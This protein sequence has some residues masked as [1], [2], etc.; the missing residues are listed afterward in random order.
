MNTTG[1][2]QPTPPAC[3]S[4][5]ATQNAWWVRLSKTPENVLMLDYDGTLAPFRVDRM[6]ASPYPG[7]VER[8]ER[9][10]QLGNSKIV[11]VSGRPVSELRKLFPFADKVDLWASHGRE[12][13]TP[14]GDYTLYELT[15]D[16]TALLNK[17]ESDLAS[18][19]L[20]PSS[21]ER[22]PANLAIHWRGLEPEEQETIRD[23]VLNRYRSLSQNASIEL[24][25][26]EDGLEFR[27][28][29]RTKADVVRAVLANL[30]EDGMAAYLGDDRTDEDAFG[31]MRSG[32]LALLVRDSP[33]ATLADY[34]LAPPEE[35]LA[36]LNQW[37]A[38]A[39]N[40]VNA[41]LAATG[42]SA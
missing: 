21:I 36:F 20:P 3:W 38:A 30:Q 18:A 27:A 7:V 42:T 32:D 4:K 25:P 31:A 12:H 19:F 11:L 10:L 15:P 6:S 33:R 2:R 26:F 39:T 35:L 24:M 1:N 22:K 5:S 29:G 8:L 28:L 9:L 13:R 17:I 23:R 16:Q 14:S 41:P 40:R 34:W 37:I